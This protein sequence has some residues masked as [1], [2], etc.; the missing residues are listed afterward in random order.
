ML[1]L[2]NDRPAGYAASDMI[3]LAMGEAGI[4]TR[5]LAG[6]FGA[7]LTFATLP[8]GAKSAPGQVSL[9]DMIGLYRFP[10]IGPATEVY[11]VIGW[12]VGHSMSPAIHN[13]GFAELGLD[14]VYVLLP[15]RPRYEN[16]AAA[17][18]GLR[19]FEELDFR[20]ASVT[21]PHKEDALRW[22]ADRGG[23]VNFE[24]IGATNTIVIGF[25]QYRDVQLGRGRHRILGRADVRRCT[26]VSETECPAIGGRRRRSRGRSGV[27]EPRCEEDRNR[28]SL[29]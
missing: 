15:V 4:V 26:S 24:E 9:A 28:E 5:V 13:A 22:A 14:K 2:L 11:G 23:Q 8:D 25:G 27:L 3:A 1:R 19:D 7:F 17:L 29:N 10:E 21:I 6:K 16:L 18:D 20:G 12:P